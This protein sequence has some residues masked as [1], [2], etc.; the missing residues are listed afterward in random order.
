[1]IEV[2]KMTHELY[3]LDIKP[4]IELK[5]QAGRATRGHPLKLSHRRAKTSTRHKSY[6]FRVVRNWNNL[7]PS[8]VSAPTLNTF[9][10]RLD[11]TWEML[12]YDFSDLLMNKDN[13][14]T[15]LSGQTG[16]II[17]NNDLDQ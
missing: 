3:D 5:H 14:G 16:H 15:I 8:V 10:N 11:K 9:K 7:A 6:S 12:K 1:M 4:I 2:Y 17:N 13:I